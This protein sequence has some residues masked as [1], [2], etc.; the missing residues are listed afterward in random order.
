MRPGGLLSWDRI[1]TRDGLVNA[2]PVTFVLLA[3]ALILAPL[4]ICV[5]GGMAAAAPAHASG[6]HHA[7][8]PAA[9]HSG[10]SSPGKAHFCPDCQP[11]SF[12][13][14]G[15]TVAPDVAPLTAA[16][17]PIAV[18]EPFTFATKRSVWTR[19]LSPRPPP[20]RRNYRIRLQI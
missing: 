15:K 7:P 2:R 3:F 4:G 13:K 18:V 19:G 1:P 9:S 20:L 16:I 17:V 6:M 10:H 14:A 11:P 5:G 12:V 8:Q